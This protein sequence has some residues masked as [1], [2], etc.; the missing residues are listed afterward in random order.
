MEFRLKKLK[1]Y[2]LM[3]MLLNLMTLIILSMRIDSFFWV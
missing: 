1:L 2:F 3:R